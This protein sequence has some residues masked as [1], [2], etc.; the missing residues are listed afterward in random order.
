MRLPLQLASFL[1]DRTLPVKSPL[2]YVVSLMMVLDKF[3]PAKEWSCDGLKLD[4][5]L[6]HPCDDGCADALYVANDENGV[7][8]VVRGQLV[9]RPTLLRNLEVH[10]HVREY[11]KHL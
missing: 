1:D 10:Q 2:R 4:K 6:Q 9:L 5:A 7:G 3:G 8:G 11:L